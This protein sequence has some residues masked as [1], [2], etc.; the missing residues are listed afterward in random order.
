MVDKRVR[1]LLIIFVEGI[2]V[3]FITSLLIIGP[4]FRKFYVGQPAVGLL[5]FAIPYV[6]LGIAVA[7][8]TIAMTIYPVIKFKDRGDVIEE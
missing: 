3:Y 7:F 2:V 6:S 5:P 1:T 4:L 8:V